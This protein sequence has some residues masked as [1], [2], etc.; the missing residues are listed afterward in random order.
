MNPTNPRWKVAG[1]SLE[2]VRDILMSL[3]DPIDEEESFFELHQ[4][5]YQQGRQ[6]L[7]VALDRAAN[8]LAKQ[9]KEFKKFL[10]GLQNTLSGD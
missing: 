6:D 1:Y 3:P 10:K 4:R 8:D 5:L 7:A 9:Q 2:L